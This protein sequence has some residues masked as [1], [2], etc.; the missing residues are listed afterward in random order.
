MTS[1]FPARLGNGLFKPKETRLGVDFV[2]VVEIVGKNITGFKPG[3]EVFGARSGTFAEYVCVQKMV[4]PKLANISFEQAGAVTV[5]GITA[6]QGLR[7]HGKLQ[8]GQKILINGASGG[9]G[10]LP[11]RSQKPLAQK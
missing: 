2:G 3:D 10:T 5:A 7:G 1:L 6:L 11:Y 4:F 8:A 9:V